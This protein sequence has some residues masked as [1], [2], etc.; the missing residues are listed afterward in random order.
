MSDMPPKMSRRDKEIQDSPPVE[1][2]R[3]SASTDAPNA[4][5]A[6]APPRTL[7]EMDWPGYKLNPKTRNWSDGS[8]T[9]NT[10]PDNL[11]R[12]RASDLQEATT[13]EAP[14]RL[15]DMNW[16]PRGYELGFQANG[17]AT[18]APKANTSP[19]RGKARILPSYGAHAFGGLCPSKD[20]GWSRCY[21]VSGSGNVNILTE[22]ARVHEAAAAA[23]LQTE[24]V[25]RVLRATGRLFDHTTGCSESGFWVEGGFFIT[26]LHIARWDSA[27]C[28]THQEL[29]LFRD[30][31]K[32]LQVS[33]EMFVGCSEDEPDAVPVYL[34]DWILQSD[35]AVFRAID[36]TYQPASCINY[37][38][39]IETQML[40]IF[41]TIGMDLS[42]H[43]VF[44]T[45]YNARDSSGRGEYMKAYR[46]KF[47]ERFQD[48]GGALT[49]VSELECCINCFF[50]SIY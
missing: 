42:S 27:D 13:A 16:P 9:P 37:R 45:G 25:S 46:D 50:F 48:S 26:T 7:H 15:R 43:L 4:T 33:C 22:K 17:S 31:A 8:G 34:L 18:Q 3:T 32:S 49:M 10:G 29:I 6:T 24:P 5:E 20:G 36:T 40:E 11:S 12:T 30:R 39:I 23:L 2:C 14:K 44:A 19:L 47:P 28:P 35:L 1:S 38:Q 21:P 41:D